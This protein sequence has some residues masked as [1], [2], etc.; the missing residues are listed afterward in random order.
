MDLEQI[1]QLRD[2]KQKQLTVLL[3]NKSKVD[4]KYGQVALEIARLEVTKRELN[5]SRQ[6]ANALIQVLKVE[7]DSLKNA[8]FNE[9]QQ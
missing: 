6:K 4:E 9:K 2:E 7:I 1:I 5:N 8:Y 3:Q